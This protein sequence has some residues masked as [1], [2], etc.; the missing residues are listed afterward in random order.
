[1]EQNLRICP[2]PRH[3]DVP[4]EIREQLYAKER[5]R[6]EKEQKTSER[7]SV[8]PA[9]RSININLLPSQSP[10][11][12]MLATP[13]G[14]PP[15]LPHPGSE[16]IDPIVVPDLPLEVAVEEYSSWQKSQVVSQRYKD[17]IDR[18]RDVALENG[19]DLEQI[20][21]DQD[22]DFFIKH[23]VR[24]GVARRFVKEIRKWADEQGLDN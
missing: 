15:F 24:I 8:E 17:D 11:S 9:G 23:G 5:K 4:S 1:M 14:S 10:Q 20:Y 7:S 18:A 3:D 12:S 6:R 13:A 22:P 19:L 21:G 16:L 2:Y